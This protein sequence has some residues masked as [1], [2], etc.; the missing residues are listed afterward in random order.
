[1]VPARWWSVFGVLGA[2]GCENN[3]VYDAERASGT[4]RRDGAVVPARADA[5]PLP[6][7][8]PRIGPEI[9]VQEA[10]LDSASCEV[11]E[12]CTV[13][14]RRRLLRFDL[15]TPNLGPGD[16]HLGAPT[17][18]ERPDPRFEW[19][20]CHEHWHLRGYADYRLM[21]R[22]GNEVGRGHKQ[23]FCLM[24]SDRDPTLPGRNVEPEEQ[25]SC[26]DQGIHAGWL[27]L[28][29]RS[30]DCQYVDISGVPPGR[31][32]LRVR[33]NVD[34]VVEEASYDD[35]EVVQEVDVPPGGGVD[36][37]VSRDPTRACDGSVTGPDRDCGWVPELTPRSCAPG[38]M[39]TLGCNARCS[40]P[41]GSCDGDAMLRACAGERGCTGAEALATNDD[42]CGTRCPQVAFT[43]PSSG[44]FTVMTAAYTAGMP[45]TCRVAVTST[46]GVTDAGAPS[47]AGSRTD[48]GTASDAGATPDASMPGN[49]TCRGP[50]V[51]AWTADPGVCLVRFAE[52]LGRPRG[53][54]F[55]PD[56]TLF[57]ASWGVVYALRDANGDG[58]VTASE[59]RTFAT[60]SGLNHGV[61]FSPDGAWLYASTPTDVYRWRWRTGL[62]VAEGSAERVVHGMSPIV[63]GMPHAGGHASRTILFDASGRLYVSVGS[64]HNM[65]SEPSDLRLRSMVRRV[66]IPAVLPAG[67]IAY[68]TGEVVA[69]GL[70]NEVGLVFDTLGRLW[71]VENGRDDLWE[72][73]FG[74]DIHEENPAE[75]LNRLDGAGSTFFGYPYC[76]TEGRLPRGGGAGTQHS[77]SESGGRSEAWCQSAANVRPPAFAMPAHWAPL[78]LTQYTG[79]VLPPAW[80][81]ALIVAS[82]GSWNHESG[83]VGR[84]IARAELRADGTIAGV[85]PAVGERGEGGS[86]R[87]GDWDV[88]PVDV[89][90][91]PDGALYFTDDSG[92]RVFRIGAR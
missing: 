38:A 78:G 21:D 20:A 30:L 89:K 84:L 13:P 31:Y 53:L 50:S 60:L 80:R 75:E 10:R 92:G 39:V 41:L 71:G 25:Y 61:A 44:R 42:A 72:T 43:C 29:A 82:H 52:G 37:G 65:D 86:L 17:T 85:T 79:T 57:V 26:E 49:A 27:D 23:S 87:E 73:R 62:L 55:A 64:A 56:G 32:R 18:G 58:A 34:R 9:E 36:G 88:R 83:Q 7:L 76:W 33:I 35:N 8:V 14:G 51:S 59:R 19:G 70:R 40:P 22:A 54:A 67:G 90:Q 3:A 12:G 63:D 74:G 66:T 77:D 15:S 47:D 45:A 6:N 48:A 68:S 4:H 1:M 91:G 69:S 24:D 28:Y 5:G 81:G 16:L 2:L 11:E 46:G